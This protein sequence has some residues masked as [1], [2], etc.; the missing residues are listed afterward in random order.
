MSLTPHNPELIVMPHLDDLPLE[1]LLVVLRDLTVDDI[2]ALRLTC[3]ALHALTYARSVWHDAL[4]LHLVSR[5]LPVPK[6]RERSLASLSSGELEDLAR[7]ALRLRKNW[8]SPTPIPMRSYQLS[9]A[10]QASGARPRVLALF[11]L[12][13]RGNRYLISL[14]L[15]DQGAR[16]RTY[17]I[18]CWDLRSPD[19]S[20]IATYKCKDLFSTAVNADPHHSHVFSIT[21]RTDFR[22][23]KRNNSNTNTSPVT[24]VLGLDLNCAVAEDAFTEGVTFPSFKHS[25]LF[26]GSTFLATDASHHVRVFN[27]ETGL[28]HYVLRTPL[29]HEDLT[30][31]LDVSFAFFFFDE[32]ER[33]VANMEF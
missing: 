19:R 30:I 27:T 28:L 6:V 25:L 8:T 15:L 23:M 13:G 5:G 9:V 26:R 7:G 29:I 32:A 2:I 24:T 3:K 14:T 17:K 10:P 16:P 31:Q 12:P 20:A 33:E 22:L 11:P 21:R 4:Y 1:V 18:D